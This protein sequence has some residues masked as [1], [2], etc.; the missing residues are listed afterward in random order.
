[1]RRARILPLAQAFLGLMLAGP[2][3]AQVAELDDFT[4]LAGSWRGPGPGGA[5]AEIHFLPPAAGVLPSFFRLVQDE[6]VLI[7]EAISLRREDDGLFMY[8]RHF[9][10]ALTPLEKDHAIKLRLERRQGDAFFFENVYEG[11]NPRRSVMER[12]AGGFVAMSE[13]ARPDGATDTIRVEYH[14]VAEATSGG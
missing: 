4:W 3:G 9:D 12:T 5:V 2:L 10:P 13:L 14:R 6:R 1:M 11:E 7:L 8:V